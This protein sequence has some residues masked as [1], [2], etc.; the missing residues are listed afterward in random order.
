MPF[1][2]VEAD[3]HHYAGLSGFQLA[4][5]E[6]SKFTD[7]QQKFCDSL[8]VLS[9]LER[10]QLHSDAMMNQDLW[11]SGQGSLVEYT[12]WVWIPIKH[13]WGTRDC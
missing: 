1:R 5:G 4:V 8:T 11:L 13:T 2:D 7:N 10:E 3:L 12:G 6:T 9:S